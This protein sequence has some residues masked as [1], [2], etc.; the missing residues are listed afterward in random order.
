[1]I[2]LDGNIAIISI[3]AIILSG[4]SS[5]VVFRAYKDK[6]IVLREYE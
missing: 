5:L 2:Y 6:E 1:M 4:V 3:Y